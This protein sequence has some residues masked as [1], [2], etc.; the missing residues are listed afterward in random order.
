MKKVGQITSIDIAYSYVDTPY[1]YHSEDDF[2]TLKD[3]F[4]P[5]DI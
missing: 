1:V 5:I 2:V 4:I 3:G